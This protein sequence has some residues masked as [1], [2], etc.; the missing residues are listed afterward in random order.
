MTLTP[1]PGFRL[2]QQFERDHHPAS[3]PLVGSAA[4]TPMLPRCEKTEAEVS[5]LETAANYLAAIA[6]DVI[7]H[8]RP[9]DR[10]NP[11]E[12]LPAARRSIAALGRITRPAAPI[13]IFQVKFNRGPVT[14]P[15]GQSAHTHPGLATGFIQGC[16]T[17]GSF[18]FTFIG[19]V[20]EAPARSTWQLHTFRMF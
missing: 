19:V 20:Q 9:H 14:Y 16:V 3:P 1:I 11:R 13:K 7:F 10:L 18:N 2:L 6:L 5:E 15:E 8:L 12:F 17:A 4:P